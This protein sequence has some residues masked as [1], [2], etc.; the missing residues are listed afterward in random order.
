MSCRS[1]NVLEVVREEFG[2]DA[3]R[4]SSSGGIPGGSSPGETQTHWRLDSWYHQLLR[5]LL[6]GAGARE[7]PL[8]KS[9]RKG[10]TEGTAEGTAAGTFSVSSSDMF[11]LLSSSILEKII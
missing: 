1:S 11:S 6:G 9:I 5:I 3:S 4:K 8:L 10:R 2:L 7:G